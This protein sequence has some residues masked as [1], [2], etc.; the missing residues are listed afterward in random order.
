MNDGAVSF[1]LSYASNSTRNDL[2]LAGLDLVASPN[3]DERVLPVLNLH[4]EGA[5]R[6]PPDPVL[7]QVAIS[8]PAQHREEAVD[9]V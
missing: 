5:F 3:V 7:G 8:Q 2:N 4:E 6:R 9:D 1:I